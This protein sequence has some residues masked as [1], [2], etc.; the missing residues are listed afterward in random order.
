M[1]MWHFYTL[2]RAPQSNKSNLTSGA[3]IVSRG[4]VTSIPVTKIGPHVR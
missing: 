1:D 3:T 2:Q 4:I